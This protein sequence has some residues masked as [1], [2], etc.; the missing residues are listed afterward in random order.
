MNCLRNVFI[1]LI[2][3]I[4]LWLIIYYASFSLASSVLITSQSTFKIGEATP[5]QHATWKSTHRVFC[6]VLTRL[7]SLGSKVKTVY[8]T[9]ARKCDN[10]KFVIK[11]PGTKINYTRMSNITADLYSD[12][13]ND[14]IE[15]NDILQ[16]ADFSKDEYKNLTNKVFMTLKYVYKK[17]AYYDWYLK[18][19]DDTF[20]FV[21]NLRKFLADKRPGEPVTYGYNFVPL[22]PHGYHSGGAGY[23]LS[24]EALVRIGRALVEN[25]HICNHNNGIEDVEVA[26]CLRRLNVFPGNSTDQY[27]RERF[28]P[29]SIF[30]R[31]DGSTYD[32][33]QK[34]SQNPVKKVTRSNLIICVC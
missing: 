17:Y 5:G 26:A 31:Y 6:F 33:L 10:F 1:L 3:T 32:W 14:A 12:T 24:H 18:A 7:D 30:E 8:D 25:E 11:F 27:G 13:I 20:V 16:L 2:M 15:L 21:D 19:D 23:V 4:V 9:W 22:V 29:L 34:Y 28:H